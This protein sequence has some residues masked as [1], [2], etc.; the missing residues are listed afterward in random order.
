MPTFVDI[1]R[2]HRAELDNM[3]DSSRDFD[4]GLYV[5]I[6]LPTALTVSR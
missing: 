1:V 2:Q 4:Y 5:I 6:N 3:I